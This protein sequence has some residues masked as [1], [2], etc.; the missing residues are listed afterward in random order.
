MSVRSVESVLLSASSSDP[1]SSESEV[2]SFLSCV[3]TAEAY[4]HSLLKSS[5]QYRWV[6]QKSQSKEKHLH[7]EGPMCKK[8][9]H[10]ARAYA[11]HL[12]NEFCMKEVRR[13]LLDSAL[14]IEFLSRVILRA[15][16]DISWKICSQHYEAFQLCCL[17]FIIL[18]RFDV[19]I[20]VG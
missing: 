7:L 10:I 12:R 4:F 3:A 18:N 17:P 16:A 5:P 6:R 1:T 11:Q 19:S 20:G 15:D 9:L 8:Q 14:V 13:C 2:V